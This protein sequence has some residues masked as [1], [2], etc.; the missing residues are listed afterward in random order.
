MIPLFA[1]WN[2]AA[3]LGVEYIDLKDA[4]IIKE[5]HEKQ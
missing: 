3:K 2:S 1:F 4:E 5:R